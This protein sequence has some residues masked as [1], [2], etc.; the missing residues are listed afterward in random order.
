M[1]R[2]DAWLTDELSQKQEVTCSPL[3]SGLRTAVC[4][5]SR[6]RT[7]AEL[8]DQITHLPDNADRSVAKQKFRI[9]NWP[10]YNKALI[11]RGS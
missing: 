10:T 6:N 11:N 5:G 4:L 9:T 7:F 2:F 3:L 1:G 8:K